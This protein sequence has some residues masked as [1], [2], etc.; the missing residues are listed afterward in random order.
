LIPS[1]QAL[2]KSGYQRY[3]LEI[4]VAGIR[5]RLTTDKFPLPTKDTKMYRIVRLCLFFFFVIA[6]F[7]GLFR[8]FLYLAGWPKFVSWVITILFFFLLASKASDYCERIFRENLYRH[9]R[10]SNPH[11][12]ACKKI[13]TVFAI[14]ILSSLLG[15]GV[16]T[17]CLSPHNRY[18]RRL[19]EKE[20]ANGLL[21]P[22]FANRQEYYPPEKAYRLLQ[23]Y[24][25][26]SPGLLG[27]GRYFAALLC[28]TVAWKIAS[29]KN[30]PRRKKQVPVTHYRGRKLYS[31]DEAKTL[32]TSL[33]QN[34][35]IGIPWGDIRLPLAATKTHLLTAGASGSG[36]TLILRMLIKAVF[37]RIGFGRDRRALVID[38]KREL[39]TYLFGMGLRCPVKII[40]PLDQRGVAWDM[41]K[42]CGDPATAREIAV[43]FIPNEGETQSY[44]VNA[45]QDILSGVFIAFHL[46]CPGR[47]TL[48]DV[49]LVLENPGKLRRLLGQH[50]E[51]Q[52]RLN[53]FTKDA[54]FLDILTT[55]STR[56]AAYRQ[57]AAAWSHAAEKI[58]L[59]DWAKG[60]FVLVLSSDESMR[61]TL[62]AINQAIF[63]RATQLLLAQDESAE[64]ETWFILDEL[65]EAG[66]LDGL[67]S[68]LTKGRSFGV[69]V[70]VG[71]Q[72]IEGLR[73]V[74]GEKE[75]NEIVGLCSNK[76]ILRLDDAQTAEWASKNLGEY[77]HY[78]T[79]TSTTT[80][81]GNK[82]TTNTIQLVKRDVVLPS[83]F[84]ELPVTDRNNGLSGYFISP[85]VGGFQT[86][87]TTEYLDASLSPPDQN[88]PN[89]I[90]R[91]ADQQYLKPWTAADL[92]R[93]QLED[94][95]DEQSPDDSP[96]WRR[97]ASR[98]A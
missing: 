2:A 4:R 47:W 67:T 26:E 32:A 41:A 86:T 95:N 83:Q 84:L 81:K 98:S 52:N 76:V 90:P 24:P 57:V 71:F 60:A 77:E 22:S 72:D 16:A 94:M 8:L 28:G 12:V 18:I 36:K 25:P 17:I 58:S 6:A 88:E 10:H 29:L 80:S 97:A 79:H 91:S 74:Y 38:G 66:K 39:L 63:K 20:G 64:R 45:A 87:L 34:A 50:S 93:L 68:L 78:E 62:D 46:N 89:F 82:S 3:S 43:I 75:A 19:I 42:D 7:T 11:R 44:F 14:G 59:R 56:I 48:R 53:Y 65:R 30:I 55:I 37:P 31:R 33:L 13:I 35:E 21:A 92:T 54:T 70:M 1:S 27:M 69:R 73:A 9:P 96:S 61:Q 23:T 85:L 49:V 5:W 51:T 40:N 15:Y